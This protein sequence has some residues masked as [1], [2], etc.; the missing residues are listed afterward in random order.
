MK[1]ILIEALL[2]LSIGAMAQCGDM[3]AQ[4]TYLTG[5]SISSIEE[6]RALPADLN[7]YFSFCGGKMVITIT[8]TGEVYRREYSLY[9]IDSRTE[10]YNC[11]KLEIVRYGCREFP[12][13]FFEVG[14]DQY[15]QIHTVLQWNT[16][17][18]AANLYFS[19]RNA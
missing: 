12:D 8:F 6:T 17:A 13:M 11:L 4:R 15:G 2:L 16:V 3:T 14:F 9:K 10:G 5:S 1:N 18:K 7:H 19:N